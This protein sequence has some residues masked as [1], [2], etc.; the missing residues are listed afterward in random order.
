LKEK[1][2]LSASSRIKVQE[3]N[4]KSLSIDEDDYKKEKEE[5]NTQTEAISKL[6]IE[7]SLQKVKEENESKKEIKTV[8]KVKQSNKIIKSKLNENIPKNS[9]IRINPQ[10]K[11][12][13]KLNEN[14]F[15]NENSLIVPPKS[16]KRQTSNILKHIPEHDIAQ[17]DTILDKSNQLVNRK[18]SGSIVKEMPS[19]P[20]DFIW[21]ANDILEQLE[22]IDKNY[23][24]SLS[25]PKSTLFGG[26]KA[27]SLNSTEID[28]FNKNL[29][30]YT[31]S[32][33]FS[34]SFLSNN[35]TKDSLTNNNEANNKKAKS[36]SKNKKKSNK[37]KIKQ[38]DIF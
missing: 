34:N 23:N 5:L 32:S 7:P 3:L 17:D 21:N 19:N 6:V 13:V 18:Q 16:I 10:T 29:R 2:I 35:F 1:S 38:E 31:S 4:I 27:Q 14:N 9:N 15:I 24:L 20:F 33:L 8:E 28:L 11:P 26:K 36:K 22:D 12:E 30:E 25:R 37:N